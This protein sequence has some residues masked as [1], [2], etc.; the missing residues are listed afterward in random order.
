M[1]PVMDGFMQEA[2]VG[3]NSDNKVCL[4]VDYSA[5]SFAAVFFNSPEEIIPGR[6]SYVSITFKFF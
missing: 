5:S 3:D 2:G 1:H 4:Q 6:I